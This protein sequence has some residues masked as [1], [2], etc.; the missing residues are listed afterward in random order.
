MY[1]F[2]IFFNCFVCLL[3]LSHLVGHPSRHQPTTIS[4]PFFPA[5]P[6]PP[7]PN[8][9][10]FFLRMSH[11]SSSA[12]HL[13]FHHHR[14][15]SLIIITTVLQL[16]QYNPAANVTLPPPQSH[17]PSYYPSHTIISP[18]PCPI[19]AISQSQNSTQSPQLAKPMIYPCTNTTKS[20]ERR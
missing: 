19:S 9:F 2:Y 4:P 5:G 7:S 17:K 6:P 14:R 10:L 20:V 13:Q 12:S 1:L 11:G 3:T 8:P 18:C 15:L 16:P